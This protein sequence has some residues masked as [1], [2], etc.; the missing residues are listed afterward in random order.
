MRTEAE[1]AIKA[2]SD[3]IAGRMSRP[4]FLKAEHYDGR[5]A[6]SQVEFLTPEELAQLAKVKPR[7]VYLWIEKRLFPFSKPPGTGQVLIAFNDAL[8]W[9][10]SGVVKVEE[11]GKP[12]YDHHTQTPGCG[13][14]K[15]PVCQ[16][17]SEEAAGGSPRPLTASASA[18][19]FQPGA[20][21]R[22]P[23]KPNATS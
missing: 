7:T 5:L 17:I 3:V 16:F 9:I 8:A 23:K 18:N 6:I 13:L 1:I 20:P 11:S 2:L 15:E 22:W 4:L 21:R 12:S 10:E 19:H 14:G